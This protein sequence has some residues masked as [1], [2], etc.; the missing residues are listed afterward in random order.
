MVASRFSVQGK[1]MGYKF[2]GGLY[3]K[4]GSYIIGSPSLHLINQ[5]K[6][7]LAGL[8]FRWIGELPSTGG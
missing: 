8:G 5:C 3:V 2:S 1:N 6:W 4:L 7:R